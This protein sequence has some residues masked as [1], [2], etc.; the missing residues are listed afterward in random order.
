MQFTAIRLNGFKSFIGPAEFRIEPGLTGVVG[1]NGCG[2]SNILES[3]RWVMGANSAKAMRA[4]A[5]DEVIFSGSANRPARNHAE[6]V[7]EID[8][9]DRTAPARFNDSDTLEVSRRL[10]RGAGSTYRI[11]G[12]EVRARDVHLLFADASSGANSPALVRQGQISELIAA[13]PQNRRR[14]LEE[15]AGISGLHNRRHEAELRLRAAENNLARLDD[16][17]GEVEAQLG[18]VR[19]QVRAATRYRNLSAHMRALEAWLAHL[20][21]REAAGQVSR[22][23]EALRQLTGAVGEHEAAAAAARARAEQASEG[24]DALRTEEAVAAALAGRTAAAVMAIENEAQEA[25]NRIEALQQRLQE[26]QRDQ[27]HE[28][29]LIADGRAALERLAEEEQGLQQASVDEDAMQRLR[30]RRD[31]AAARRDAAESALMALQAKSAALAAD[32]RAAEQACAQAAEQVSRARAEIARTRISDE[33]LAAQENIAQAVQEARAALAAAETAAQEARQNLNA[34]E[35]ARQQAEQAERSRREAFDEARR[36]RAALAAEAEGLGRALQ[37]QDGGEWPDIARELTVRPGYERAL[38]AALGDDL[39]ASLEEQAPVHWQMGV[40]A[41]ADLPAPARPL[42]ACVEAPPQLAARLSQT[43][44]VDED[45]GEALAALLKPGQRLVSS[46]GRLWRWDGLRARA[47]APSAAAQRLQQRNR[48]DALSGMLAQ[49]G[50]QEESARQD[51][52]EAR[53]QAAAARQAEKA[54]RQAV[55]AQDRALRQ[56]QGACAA[57]EQQQSALA[58]RLE[59]QKDAAARW[60]QALDEALEKAAQ[61]EAR[62]AA[63]PVHD[64]AA[65]MEELQNAEKTALEWRAAA[66]EAEAALRALEHDTQ[67]RAARLQAIASER[68]RWR[69]RVQTASKRLDMLAQRHAAA[70]AE[71]AE[72]KAVPASIASRREDLFAAR[73]EAEQRRARAAEALE[74]AEQARRQAERAAREAEAQTARLR[75]ER[76]GAEARL[77]A[78]QDRRDELVAHIQESMQCAP[79][80]LAR[81]AETL[82]NR[83][84]NAQAAEQKLESLR[85]QRESIGPVNL[86]AAEEAQEIEERLQA[87]AADREDLRAAIAKLRRGIESLNAEGRTRLL[88]AFD[89]VNGHFRSLFQT[90]FGGGE[91]E[92]RLTEADDPLDAGLEIFASPPGKKLESMTL[93]SGGEQA[94][95]AVALIFAVFLSNPA[96]VC[97]L[98]EVEAPLDDANVDRFCTLLEEMRRRTKTRFIVIT[99]NAVTMS[100]VDR[101]YG[102]TMAERGVSQLVSVDLRRA[103]TLAAA[104]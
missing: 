61:A 42:S 60:Q 72:A 3:L 59:A 104:E 10:T 77:Q 97:V 79:D 62:A 96:P 58:A 22:F 20:R 21:W 46:S 18:Q 28:Q 1:P 84:E 86:R 12:A 56:A 67:A 34:A 57:L 17:H 19:R 45:A 25:Q 90:L 102:V 75:E 74:E 93:L 9:S 73:D 16:I 35:S 100:R 50:E 70:E 30:Q 37:G 87:M 29:E 95:T 92:L 39:Q 65:S 40:A 4:D 82:K 78:A 83:P 99:H 24:L 48:L 80:E 69:Q 44:L 11:N 64:D 53:D 5:M 66:A 32:R 91:A 26:L 76:A 51:W 7:L 94:L 71:L 23:E 38:A 41:D 14:V 36:D 33:D 6:V 68:E 2:K 52:L 63:L 31:E 43:G 85:R 13:K 89:E 47:G 88:A 27:E 15:A 49:A 54:A 81:Q 98:D 55:Q 101:L 103:E 8:N